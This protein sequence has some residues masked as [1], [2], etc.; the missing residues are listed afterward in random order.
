M[1]RPRIALLAC[2][3]VWLSHTLE[4][5]RVWGWSGLNQE[6]TGS[7]HLYMVPV[8]LALVLVV[9]AVGAGLVRL[10]R[11]LAR[12][13]PA[14]LGPP[15]RG[16]WRGRPDCSLT[17][18]GPSPRD[19]T[20]GGPHHPSPRW[21]PRGAPGRPVP[22]PGEP[23]ERADRWLRPGLS[24][25]PGSTGPRRSSMRWWAPALAAISVAPLV[26]VPSTPGRRRAL[27]A[28][29]A[30][31]LAAAAARRLR[32][33]LAAR[34]LHARPRCSGISRGVDLVPATPLSLILTTPAPVPIAIV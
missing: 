3:G 25:I 23:R 34:Q 22:D 12:R 16:I 6:L 1:A 17:R 15:R 26:R 27:R 18:S 8:G 24:V 31:V 5:I 4:Y 10:H 14:R 33:L 9:A 30:G 13:A 28:G 2:V 7:V 21:L 29:C 19:D 20:V 32:P 11:L